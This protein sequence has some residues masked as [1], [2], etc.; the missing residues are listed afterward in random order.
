VSVVRAGTFR[1]IVM[2]ITMKRVTCYVA[3]STRESVRVVTQWDEMATI[4]VLTIIISSTANVLSPGGSGYC[5][6]T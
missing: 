3:R 5:A 1:K 6:C 2:S 4:F